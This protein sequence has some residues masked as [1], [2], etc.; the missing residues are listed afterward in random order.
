VLALGAD[1][2]ADA[3]LA[4]AL[5]DR[6]QHDVMMPMPPTRSE[7]A[8]AEPRRIDNGLRHLGGRGGDLLLRAQGEV[9]LLPGDDAVPLAQQGVDL[10]LRLGHQ[11]G[12]PRG[13]QHLAD[14][15]AAPGAASSPWCTER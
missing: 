1:R 12:G 6:D 14:A 9:G 2:Q 13:D 15:A 11:R 8:A 10:G 5:G 7:I 4:G 3:D